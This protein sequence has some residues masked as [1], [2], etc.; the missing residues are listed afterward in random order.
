MKERLLKLLLAVLLVFSLVPKAVFAE[1]DEASGNTN[2]P[3]AETGNDPAED[4]DDDKKDPVVAE[5]EGEE[6][7]PVTPVPGDS[8]KDPV[9]PVD[10]EEDKKEEDKKEEEPQGEKAEAVADLLMAKKDDDVDKQEEEQLYER[11]ILMYVI[12]SDLESV[13]GLASFNLE[14]ILNSYFSKGNKIKYIIMTGGTDENE[15]WFLDSSYL[16]DPNGSN[17]DEISNEYN[18][19]WEAKG[20]DAAEN[21]GKLVLLDGDGIFNKPAKPVSEEDAILHP[22]KYEWMSDPEVLKAFINYG[23]NNYPA[24]QYDLILWDHGSGPMGGY[25]M[26]EHSG[27]ML[28]FAQLIDVFSDNNLTRAGKKFDIINFDAC[29]MNSIELTL[30]FAPYTDYYIASPELVPGDG[31]YYSGWL[32]LLGENPGIDGYDLGKKI[33]DDFYY[34]YTEGEGTQEGTLALVN[35]KALV[36]SGIVSDLIT[37]NNILCSELENL[38]FYDELASELN[39]IHYGNNLYY[40]DLGNLV[41]QI[42]VAVKEFDETYVPVGGKDLEVNAYY[43]VALRILK[44]L[45][46]ETIIYNCCTKGIHTTG[47]FMYRDVDG[48][49]IFS[50]PSTIPGSGLESSGTYIYFTAVNYYRDTKEYITEI[51]S[52]IEKLP[53]GELKAFLGEYLKTMNRWSI[54]VKTGQTI[55]QMLND[56]DLDYKKEDLDYETVEGRW[57]YNPLAGDESGID[58]SQWNYYMREMVKS[59]SETF[60]NYSEY[61]SWMDKM[62][63]QMTEEAIV[64][65]NISLYEAETVEGK[66]YQ[67]RFSDIKKRVIENV[68]YNLVAEIPILRDYLIAE[69]ME[70]MFD[71]QNSKSGELPIGSVA[72]SEEFDMDLDKT[73][74]ETFIEDYIRWL[75]GSEAKWNLDPIDEKWFALKDAEGKLHVVTME[76]YHDYYLIPVTYEIGGTDEAGYPLVEMAALFFKP[77]ENSDALDLSWLMINDGGAYRPIDAQD[78][79][80]SMT[81]K[82]CMAIELMVSNDYAPISTSFDIVYDEKT[83]KNNTDQIK[84]VFTDIDNIPDI[85]DTTGDGKKLTSQ[86]V[87]TDIYGTKINISDMIDKPDGKIYDINFAKVMDDEYDGK[88]HS[89]RLVLNGVTLKEGRDYKISVWE[90]DASFDE[91]GEYQVYLEGMGDYTGSGWMT[92]RILPGY[93]NKKGANAI[94]YKGSGNGCEFTY[95]RS[96][97]PEMT[98]RHFAD[99]AKRAVKVDGKVVSENNYEYASGSLII[100]LKPEYLNSL[101]VGN[102]AIVVVFDDNESKPIRFTIRDKEEEKK[103]EPAHYIFPITGVERMYISR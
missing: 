53:D 22:E 89:P 57:K 70:W 95:E 48:D 18:C 6:G 96:K 92:Y 33:V 71:G 90:G 66:G 83:G 38:K 63:K 34:Y 12:G 5:G 69:K 51:T 52:V 61:H 39:S 14:Q 78:L 19:I 23:V 37:M 94:W 36:N 55:T 101:S 82:P 74:V 76:M 41:S 91:I 15:G 43:D 40:V 79:K 73:T 21:P 1:G 2:D 58:F 102:H 4:K 9:N 99:Y 27:N 11:T 62:V 30:A 87:V 46:N 68:S 50:D 17:P 8:P 35:T 47:D 44:I 103:H 16:Y 88:K 29:L 25:G 77:D 64:K 32:N 85:K 98:Y 59:V 49:V 26:D 10:S 72:G 100:R 45:Q 75:N 31:E 65:K 60:A 86:I 24:K 42:C 97:D 3:I 67:V 56:E 93:N 28:S 20:K 80:K 54:L 84:L 13:S 7:D 81:L